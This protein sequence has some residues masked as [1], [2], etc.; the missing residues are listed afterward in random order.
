MKKNIFWASV[1]ILGFTGI[2]AQAEHSE[3]T[4]LGAPVMVTAIAHTEKE[5]HHEANLALG[6]RGEAVE[7][8][9]GFL[10]DAGLLGEGLK[11]GYFGTLTAE[12]LKAWQTKMSLPATGYFGPMTREK[13]AKHIAE[14]HSATP[15]HHETVEASTSTPPTVRIEATKDTMSGYNLRIMTT[16]FAITPQNAGGA[17]VAGEGHMHLYVNEKKVGRVYGEWYHIPG[18]WFQKGNNEI[19][20]TLNGNTHADYVLAGAVV[21]ATTT[22]HV[23]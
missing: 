20:V 14:N 12:A 11:T 23:D 4:I 16:Q 3:A 7:C 19:R 21:G 6:T 5:C 15:V 17:H 8:L 10:H 22:V 9:Q 13:L 18:T 2:I 1:I